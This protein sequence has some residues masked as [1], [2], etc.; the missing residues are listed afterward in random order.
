MIPF[1]Q[2][3]APRHTLIHLSDTHLLAGG[4][5]LYGRLDTEGTLER[6]LSQ[7][8]RSGIRPEAIVITGDLAD[9]GEPDAYRRLR[10]LVESAASTLGARVIWVMGNHDER[11][12]IAEVLLDRE[13]TDE[14]L[15]AVHDLNG[16]RLVVLDSTV[17]GYHHGEITGSQLAWLREVLAEPARHGSLLALHHPPIPT[18]V[19]LMG[20]LELKEQARLADALR[21][22]DVRA[23][24]AGHL[25][26]SAQSTFAGIPVSVTGATCYT[27]DLSRS[28]GALGGVD[29]GQSASVVQVYDEV[30]VHSSTPLTDSPTVAGF[31]ADYIE[32]LRGMSVEARIDEFSRK[33]AP[34]PPDPA[35]PGDGP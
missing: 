22:T 23:I 3:P 2:H 25:H 12:A 13:P 11:A 4:R 21:G 8:A 9:L 5:P 29:V 20:V 32:R 31:D 24:L 33:R 18:P 35:R 26:H 17:P 15:D 7:L 16:L 34:V 30:I 14:P 6:M 28:V 10:R 19:E 1:G 27:I